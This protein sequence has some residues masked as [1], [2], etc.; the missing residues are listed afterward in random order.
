E[1]F[2]FLMTKLKPYVEIV[3]HNP[4]FWKLTYFEVLTVLAFT[5]FREK[6]VDFQVLEVGLGGRLDATNV[7]KP[8]VCVI[9]PI[10]RDHTEILGDNLDKIVLE[11]AGIV[12]PGCFVVSSPQTEEVSKVLSDVCRTQDVELI[13]VGKDIVWHSVTNDFHQQSFI[14]EGR[15]EL[16]HLTVPLLG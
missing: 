15:G 16:Y 4:D 7:A 1:E 13:Q 8:D 3:N 14:V 12:K 11:K 6:Q 9:T 5:Y 10:S 2:A